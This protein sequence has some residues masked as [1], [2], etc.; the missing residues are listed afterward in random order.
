MK[1]IIS[2]S[3]A[4]ERG[5]NERGDNVSKGFYQRWMLVRSNDVWLCWSFQTNFIYSLVL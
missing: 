2:A 3:I 4:A 1:T 5:G